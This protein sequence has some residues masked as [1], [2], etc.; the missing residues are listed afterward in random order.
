MLRL[1]PFIILLLSITIFSQSLRVRSAGNGKARISNGKV[2]SVINLQKDISG[3]LLTYD[4]SEQKRKI[5]DV[6]GFKLI[7]S[8]TKGNT[9]YLV[10][11][12]TASGNC[13]VTGQCGAA[14]SYTLFW[15]KLNKALKLID[16]QVAIAQDCMDDINLTE[17]SSITLNKG[18][19]RIEYEDNLYRESLDYSI[20]KL[21]YKHA[22]AEK[23]FSIKTEKGARPKN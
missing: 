16:K 23:G 7:D 20:T 3:C 22:E 10:L 21:V 17:D 13:N 12:A 8:V 18:I 4:R 1:V 19:L 15:L 11:L 5:F 14:E 6:T 2:Q 9:T